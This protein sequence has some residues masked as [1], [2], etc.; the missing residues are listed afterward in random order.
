MEEISALYQ[1]IQKQH[2]YIRQYPNA[3]AGK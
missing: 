1:S 3:V 2:E